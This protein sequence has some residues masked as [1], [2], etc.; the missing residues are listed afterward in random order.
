MRGQG[1]GSKRGTME[2]PPRWLQLPERRLHGRLAF[3][4]RTA[5]WREHHIRGHEPLHYRKDKHVQWHHPPLTCHHAHKRRHRTT[6][7]ILLRGLPRQNGLNITTICGYNII[8]ATNG[9]T[10]RTF[11]SRLPLFSPFCLHFDFSHRHF[12]ALFKNFCLPVIFSA[13]FA[14]FV[15]SCKPA[16]RKNTLLRSI[17]KV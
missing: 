2:I 9:L 11:Q 7:Q 16:T 10:V 1:H 5:D 4:P 14:F 17:S 15:T 13:F 6:T 3:R 8:A 12:P